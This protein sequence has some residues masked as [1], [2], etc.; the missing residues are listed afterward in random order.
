MSKTSIEYIEKNRGR[1]SMSALLIVSVL[2]L[3]GVFF[4]TH[5]NEVE[6]AAITAASDT[7]NNSA[8]SSTAVATS[9]HAIAFTLPTA[10]SA[11]DTITI[12]FPTAFSTSSGL[13]FSDMDIATATDFALANTSS[14]AT[15]G[16][17]TSGDI[18]VTFTAG[19]EGTDA[20]AIM[21]IEIGDNA[22]FGG[23]GNS[24]IQNP[25]KVATPGTADIYTISVG[26]TSDSGDMLVAIIEGVAVSVT[27]DES[28]AFTATGTTGAA[29]DT[30]FGAGPTEVETTATTVPF[31]TISTPNTFLHGCQ[32]LSVST[33]AS[34]GYVVAAQTNTSLKSGAFLINNGV[35]DAS[36]SETATDTW[37]DNTING[38]A[39]SSTGTDSI[40]R[41]TLQYKTFA[42]TDATT[43]DCL[44]RGGETGQTFMSNSGAVS[45]ST[46]T[47]E[48]KLSFS[49]T[50]EAGTYGNTV[51][52]IVT[53]TF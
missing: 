19:S 15:W 21:T 34:S 13:D 43:T 35:C 2:A 32:E 11:S 10:L 1:I 5:E 44:P 16:A 17:T 37:A 33:N 26:G 3:T 27:I 23:T 6:G 22:T 47:V 53:P 45:N 50:Q 20:G 31:G 49:G 24:Y 52:Y 42:C 40:I 18:V 14:G 9:N 30:A 48:F 25:A 39:Y 38:F 29:C 4:M 36:C 46:T 12:T 51:T 28:L 8:P 41:S 7:M